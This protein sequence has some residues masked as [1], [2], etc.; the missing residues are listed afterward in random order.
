MGEKLGSKTS[1]LCKRGLETLGSKIIS[2]EKA[3]RT[4]VLIVERLSIVLG[5]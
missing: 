4:L 5:V 1:F 3:S 2:L